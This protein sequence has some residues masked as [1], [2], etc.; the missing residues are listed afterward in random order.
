[1]PAKVCIHCTTKRTNK[2]ARR[3]RRSTAL[4]NQRMIARKGLG[5]LL[6]LL[7][8]TGLAAMMAKWA[9]IVGRHRLQNPGQQWVLACNEFCRDD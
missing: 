3:P 6:C 1:L 9:E 8:A 5:L 2:S 4:I 7:Q